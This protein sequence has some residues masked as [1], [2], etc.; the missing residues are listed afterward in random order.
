RGHDHVAERQRR[1]RA[2]HILFHDQHAAR[3]LDVEPAAVEADALAD[4]GD[5]FR[6]LLAPGEVDEPWRARAGAAH[7]MD[8]R[9]VLGEQ[10]RP[11]DTRQACAG[12][13]GELPDRVLQLRGTEVARR[14]VDE[15]AAEPYP[16]DRREHAGEVG[17]WDYPELGSVVAVGR[18]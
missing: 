9:E 1:G 7:G 2:A 15:I 16:F 13:R 11:A 18:L 4:Q 17:A 8:H 14:R 5:P 10:I 6:L 3:R 12:P